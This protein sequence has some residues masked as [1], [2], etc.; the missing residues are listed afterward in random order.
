[1]GIFH[2]KVADRI[3]KL[4]AEGLRRQYKALT[5]EIAFFKSI[6]NSLDEG[7]VVLD[8]RGRVEYANAVGNELLPLLGCGEKIQGG[9]SVPDGIS[10]RE[11]EIT[12][13]E[14]RV[15]E[16]KRMRSRAVAPMPLARWRRPWRMRS[17]IRSM[18]CP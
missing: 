1:M 12:Y 7:I 18:H 8:D 14:H 6:F 3:G 13:P 15:I 9:A 10:V 5:D 4:D 2:D 16:V 11:L 17:A